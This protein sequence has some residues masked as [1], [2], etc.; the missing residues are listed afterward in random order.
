VRLIA[1][2]PARALDCGHNI[3]MTFARAG[4][5]DNLHVWRLQLLPSRSA[6]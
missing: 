1:H 3:A 6:R 5:D 2:E 4:G